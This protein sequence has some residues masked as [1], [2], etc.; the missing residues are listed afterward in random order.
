M[1][2]RMVFAG[3]AGNLLK[4]SGPGIVAPRTIPM[5]TAVILNGNPHLPGLSNEQIINARNAVKL[6][7][8]FII[9]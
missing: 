7:V 8:R 5:N 1:K 4:V 2:A 3:G 6:A 9:L